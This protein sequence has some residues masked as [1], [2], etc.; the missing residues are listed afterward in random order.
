MMLDRRTFLAGTGLMT[1]APA[2]ELVP[3][4]LGASPPGSSN[5][6][7]FLID[8]WS[9]AGEAYQPDQMSLRL[10]QSWRAAWR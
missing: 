9:V 2:F 7:A 6:L 10:G 1:V 5:H 4:Q 3:A 8:G